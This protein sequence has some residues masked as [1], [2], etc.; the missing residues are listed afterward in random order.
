ME[1]TLKDELF[2]ELIKEMVPV[3]ITLLSGTE[4]IGRIM[5]KDGNI[6]GFSHQGKHTIIYEQAIATIVPIRHLRS[7][8]R[9]I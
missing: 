2:Q 3:T 5:A 4:L 8:A 7:L 6:I 1:N 9:S